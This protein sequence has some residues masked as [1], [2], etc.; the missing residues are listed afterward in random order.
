MHIVGSICRCVVDLHRVSCV[1]NQMTVRDVM[2]YGVTALPPLVQR[3]HLV[4]VL[5]RCKYAVRGLTSTQP[6]VACLPFN[7]HCPVK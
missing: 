6:G 1:T 5:R 4:N 7:S 3:S 2:T